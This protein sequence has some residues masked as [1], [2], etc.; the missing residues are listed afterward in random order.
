[1]KTNNHQ[2]K[3]TEI[4]ERCFAAESEIL[5]YVEQNPGLSFYT[6]KAYAYRNDKHTWIEAMEY[7]LTRQT[8]ALYIRDFRKSS[9]TKYSK[10]FHEAYSEMLDEAIAYEKRKKQ[11]T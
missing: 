11:T 2:L 7:R 5:E 9:K 1:M 3:Y 8:I 4:F 10:P 6:L